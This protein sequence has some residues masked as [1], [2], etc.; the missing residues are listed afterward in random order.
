M[1]S[2]SAF[3]NFPNGNNFNILSCD[4]E[5]YQ[6]V[7]KHNFPNGN[8]RGGVINILIEGGSEGKYNDLVKWAVSYSMMLDGSINFL[9]GDMFGLSKEIDFFNAFCIRYRE[10]F[11][12]TGESTTALKIYLT[13]SAKVIRINS[14]EAPENKWP[15]IASQGSPSEQSSGKNIISFNTEETTD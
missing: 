6:P 1:A 7:D 5:V 4:Y 10:V 8:P 3:L 14:E 9:K 12:S 13:I 15:G 11:S 2:F